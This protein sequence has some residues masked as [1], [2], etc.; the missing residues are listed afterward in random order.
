MLK[1]EGSEAQGLSTPP[2]QAGMVSESWLVLTL[3]SKCLEQKVSLY[4]P[5]LLLKYDPK[6]PANV[7]DLRD[8]LMNSGAY[9]NMAACTI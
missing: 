1:E 7:E 2:R 9:G 4:S 6:I 5:L 3:P 8:K